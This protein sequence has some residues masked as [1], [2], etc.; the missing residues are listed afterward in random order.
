MI[1]CHLNV[2]SL[3]I[4]HLDG[5]R[6]TTVPLSISP[7]QD[8]RDRSSLEGADPQLLPRRYAALLRNCRCR[9]RSTSLQDK[10][11]LQSHCYY[12]FAA[13]DTTT[14]VVATK[15]HLLL[16][17]LRKPSPLLHLRKF[18]YPPISLLQTPAAVAATKSHAAEALRY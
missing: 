10:S 8:R 1:C 14:A 17:L 12:R 9:R 16:P 2:H 6:Q 11:S 18:R 3:I 7:S 5:S 15:L 4:K 13:V